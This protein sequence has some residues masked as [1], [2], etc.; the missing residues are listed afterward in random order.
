MIF[1]AV[2]ND[3]SIQNKKQLFELV[4]EEA[5]KITGAD[6]HLIKERLVERD[7]LLPCNIGDGVAVPQAELPELDEVRV[8][9]FKIKNPLMLEEGISM[10]VDVVSV[11]LAP[12]EQG[13]ENLTKLSRVMRMMRN[14]E[15]V[16]LIRG[17]NSV[18]AIEAILLDKP[19]Y[20]IA[21]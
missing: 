13:T 18:D 6:Y 21:A 19:N 1:H 8:L 9:V 4:A 7:K 20:Q 14:R 17:A 3:A 16:N 11:F 2:M 5:S 15:W 10:P 12:S